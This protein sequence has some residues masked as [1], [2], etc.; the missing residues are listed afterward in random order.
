MGQEQDN[1]DENNNDSY[2]A[3]N[4]LHVLDMTTMTWTEV[5][6]SSTAEGLP[7]KRHAHS[8]TLISPEAAILYGGYTGV[9]SDEFPYGDC[10]LL[11]PAEV[12]QGMDCV[13]IYKFVFFQYILYF[14]KVRG[15]HL[16]PFGSFA[17]HRGRSYQQT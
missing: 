6:T 3:L 5:H 17:S 10:W 2:R 11:N 4:D 12:L 7:G 16:R 13:Y 1:S 9:R 14:Y 15:R 8:M